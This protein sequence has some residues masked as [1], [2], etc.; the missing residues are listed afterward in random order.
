MTE[1]SKLHILKWSLGDTRVFIASKV[2]DALDPGQR[3]TQVIVVE[4]RGRED[5]LSMTCDGNEG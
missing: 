1:E 5:S 4:R 2:C 3:G